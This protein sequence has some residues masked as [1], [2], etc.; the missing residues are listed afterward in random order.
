MMKVEVEATNAQRDV[1]SETRVPL[2]SPYRFV[3]S[4]QSLMNEMFVPYQK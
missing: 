3:F 1:L 4:N 2:D